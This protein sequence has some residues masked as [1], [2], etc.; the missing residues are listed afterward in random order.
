[1]H[2]LKDVLLM[3]M[4]SPAIYLVEGCIVAAEEASTHLVGKGSIPWTSA[5]NR[6]SNHLLEAQRWCW[7]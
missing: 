6:S 1:M 3:M 5:V 2:V 7:D 4:D